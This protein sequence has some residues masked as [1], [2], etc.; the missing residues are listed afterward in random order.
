MSLFS[1][2]KNSKKSRKIVELYVKYGRIYLYDNNK[3]GLLDG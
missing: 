3:G 2:G 1:S